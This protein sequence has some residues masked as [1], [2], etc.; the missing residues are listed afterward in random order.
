[1]PDKLASENVVLE[2]VIGDTDIKQHL[3]ITVGKAT[4]AALGHV[5][6]VKPEMALED[7]TTAFAGVFGV[8]IAIILYPRESII[9]LNVSIR[10]YKTTGSGET[11][12]SMLKS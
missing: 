6:A 2:K 11:R 9:D 8:C 5:F 10:I 3:V 12:L 4:G 7:Q 1:L